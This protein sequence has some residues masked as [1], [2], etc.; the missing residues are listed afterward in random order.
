[1]IER[2]TIKF[3]ANVEIVR[4]FEKRHIIMNCVPKFMFTMYYPFIKL[5]HCQCQIFDFFFWSVG[6]Y[7]NIPF[8][9]PVHKIVN[10]KSLVML[11]ELILFFPNN[12]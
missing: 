5:P 6:T 9:L 11:M 4:F 10:K 2:L 8:Q 3:N 12:N 7:G 1:M